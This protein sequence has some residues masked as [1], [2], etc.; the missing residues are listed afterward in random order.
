VASFSLPSLLKDKTHWGF[1]HPRLVHDL[2][3]LFLRAATN[4]SLV[5]LSPFSFLDLPTKMS[6]NLERLRNLSTGQGDIV[7][8]LASSDQNY[9]SIQFAMT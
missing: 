6:G 4:L 9:Q 1:L 3:S 8:L 7:R 5:I 2:F